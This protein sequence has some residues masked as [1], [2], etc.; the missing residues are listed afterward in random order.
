V[1]TR[2]WVVAWYEFSIFVPLCLRINVLF[3]FKTVAELIR[4]LEIKSLEEFF[5][6]PNDL[7]KLLKLKLM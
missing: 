7:M 3:L 1:S 4:V 6:H 2:I 5:A